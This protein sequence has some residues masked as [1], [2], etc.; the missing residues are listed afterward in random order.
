MSDFAL[1]VLTR[2]KTALA[3]RATSVLIPGSEGDFQVLGN[4]APIVSALRPGRLVA[5]CS[6]EQRDVEVTGGFVVVTPDR[7]DVLVDLADL[8]PG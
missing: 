2:Q 7:V 3:T 1:R 6:G 5:A 8:K 4:H